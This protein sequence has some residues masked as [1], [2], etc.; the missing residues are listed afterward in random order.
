MAVHRRRRGGCGPPPPDPK[1]YFGEDEICHWENLVEPF[2]VHKILGSLPFSQH[3]PRARTAS[4]EGGSFTDPDLQSPFG[5]WRPNDGIWRPLLVFGDAV[6]VV[7]E[8]SRTRPHALAGSRNGAVQWDR[9]CGAP[10]AA[11]GPLSTPVPKHLC[12][13]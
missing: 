11:W 1:I 9:G 3:I 7:G 4:A 6:P 12:G 10:A 2:L 8:P 13:P 5:A